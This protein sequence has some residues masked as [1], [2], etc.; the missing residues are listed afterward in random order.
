MAS[1]LWALQVYEQ[2]QLAFSSSGRVSA[3]VKIENI[4]PARRLGISQAGHL[5]DWHMPITMTRSGLMRPGLPG[6]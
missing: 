3:R 4:A 1:D 5:A 2:H 6:F